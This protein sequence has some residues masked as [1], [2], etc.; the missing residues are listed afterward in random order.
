MLDAVGRHGYAA[1]TVDELVALAGI[2]K[3]T[4][5]E[6]FPDKEACFVATMEA[7]LAEATRRIGGAYQSSGDFREAMVSRLAAF[8]D[9]VV[10]EPEAARL[11]AVE[12]LTLGSS[13]VAH[14][15]RASEVFESVARHSIDAAPGGEA[16]SDVVVRAVVNGLSGIV[17]RR[18]RAGRVTELPELVEPLVDW[19]VGYTRPDNEALARAI[20]AAELPPW[21][22]PRGIVDSGT[23]GWDEPPDSRFSRE[24][25]SQRERIRRAA[26]RVVV[27]RGYGQ[28][29][30]PAIS[31][32]AGTSNQ[33]FYEC[34]ADKQEAFLNAFEAVAGEAL[35]Y[36]LCAFRNAGE[37][38]EAIGAGLRGLLEHIACH[39]MFARL[40]FFELPAAGPEA[41]DRAD[42][43][44]D[45]VTAFLEPPLAPAGIG[46]PVPKAILEAIG[47]GIWAVI[48]HEIANDRGDSLPELAPEITRIALGPLQ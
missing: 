47:T 40:A 29:S 31:R 32:V 5:Y 16:V 14:R 41:L 3:S 36:A 23:A 18:L 21:S 25:L 10:E 19:A 44:M 33:T 37:G 2:S 48:Q 46:E 8:M 12:S 26:A 22:D 4:F 7:I 15:A 11:A 45:A 13:G 30:V 20:A 39:P 6:R 28:L 24:T 35:G 9:L 17:Y 42:A 1:T 34:F 38:P 27:E 43:I